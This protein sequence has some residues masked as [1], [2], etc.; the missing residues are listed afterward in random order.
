MTDTTAA[1]NS[2][3][4]AT[5]ADN[6]PA[7]PDAAALAKEVADYKDKLLR[8]LADMENLRR[9]TDRE[10]A[11]ARTYGVSSLARDIAGVA[12]NMRRALAAVDKSAAAI[13]GPAKALVEGVE[14]IERELLKVL[15]KHGVKKF[16]PQGVKFDPNLH[17]AIFEVS[18]VNVASGSIAQVIQPGYMIGERVLRP[19]MVGVSKG[20]PKTPSPEQTADEKQISQEP[21]FG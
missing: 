20:G 11:D 2:N 12:D 5:T 8:S 9:R 16:D 4:A 10:V 6:E 7:L 17:Q 21:D 1:A 3:D 18:D 14:L 19:A 15:E 13:E